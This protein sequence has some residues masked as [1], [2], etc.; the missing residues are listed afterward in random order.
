M[1]RPGP[2]VQRI[3]AIVAAH[4]SSIVEI[5]A[6]L[7][8]AERVNL[9]QVLQHMVEQR[10]LRRL[11]RLRRR[12]DGKWRTIYVRGP[13]APSSVAQSVRL[14]VVRPITSLG[15]PRGAPK[16][17]AV[18][19][20]SLCNVFRIRMPAVAPAVNTVRTVLGIDRMTPNRDIAQHILPVGRFTIP[21]S[22]FSLASG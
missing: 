17:S 11:K 18:A 4:P 1:A 3:R 21:V 9:P 16:I 5:S 10:Y 2:R 15:S 14:R 12:P 6:Q 13:L 8:P 19:W 22:E 7:E 20:A